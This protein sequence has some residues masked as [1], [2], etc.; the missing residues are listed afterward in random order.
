MRKVYFIV[1][2]CFSVSGVEI[3]GQ[4]LC[5]IDI[6]IRYWG[7]LLWSITVC[8]FSLFALLEC[9]CVCVL[10]KCDNLDLGLS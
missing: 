6:E 5:R 2:N 8:A 10:W 1:I 3:R 9:A 4:S 7:N